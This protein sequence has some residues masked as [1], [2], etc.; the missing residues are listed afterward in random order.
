MATT[1][2]NLDQTNRNGRNPEDFSD[3]IDIQ[4]ETQA[5]ID[6]LKESTINYSLSTASAKSDLTIERT[7]LEYER[8]IHT[9]VWFLSVLD[10]LLEEIE[11]T[12]KW[13]S[14]KW[15]SKAWKKTMEEAKAKL[16]QYEKQLK[17]KKKTLLK[18]KRAE[19]YDND[20]SNLK[21]LW[22]QVNKVREDIWMWQRGEFSSTAS[23]LYNSPEIA[24]KSNKRQIDNIKFNQKLQKELKD[25]A[26]LRIFWWSEQKANSYYTRIAQ[27]EYDEAD[28]Q[29]YLVNEQI[30][31]PSFQRCEID[32]PTDPRYR[33]VWWNWWI[34]RTSRT[35][36]RSTDY[37]NMDWWDTLQKWWVAGVLDKLLS[38]CNNMTPWQR[39][40]W[41]SL[42]VLACFAGWIYWLYKFYTNKN[43]G[44]WSKAWITAWVIFGSQFLTWEWPISLFNKLIWWWLS[45]EELKNKFGNAVWWLWSSSS[46]FMET[47]T[48]VSWWA[49]E[50]VSETVV[51]AMYSMMIFNSSTKVSD[52][53]AMTQSFKDNNNRKAFYHQSCNT[54]EKEYWT[55]AAEC[56]RATFSDNFDEEKWK[57]RLASFG[58]T[59]NTSQWESLYWLANNATMNKII[60]EKFQTENWLIVTNKDALNAYIQDKKTNNQPID[61]DDLNNHINNDWT[62]RFK[63]DVKKTH[64]DRPED[65]TNREKLVN[66]VE[67][68]SLDAYQKEKL[69]QAIQDFYDERS[70]ENKPNLNDFELKIDWNILTL[71]SQNWNETKIDLSNNSLKINNVHFAIPSLSEALNTADLTNYI[72][73]LTNKKNPVDIPPFKYQIPQKAICFNDN[74]GKLNFFDTAI[75]NINRLRNR[76]TIDKAPNIYASYLSER[77]KEINKIN[78]TNYPLVKQLWISFYSNENE[79]KK[80]ENYLKWVKEKLKVFKC[81]PDWNP[82]TIE[83][84]TNRLKFKAINWDTEY[85]D[86]NIS[87]EFPTLNRKWNE[88]KFLNAINNPANKMR[89][90][91]FN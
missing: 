14:K 77:R 51:P 20:I 47:T 1:R 60:L 8:D 54:L 68:L 41:R 12:K 74:S 9:L 18:Q 29:L 59:E 17:G 88:K 10:K 58:V 3:I 49:W 57:N 19:I 87:K 45:I 15:L 24:K 72:L 66:K 6:N 65:I 56:F 33:I 7:W 21:N 71:K 63:V 27:W 91:V 39:E 46:W 70:I 22:N 2:W 81:H 5:W 34:E 69:K 86:E 38:N 11:D 40:T 62:D 35:V 43:M 53:N 78:L 67:S 32:I 31:N 84:L 30:L 82:F 75:L 44:F 42:W 26:I 23:Y 83:V 61:V 16:N 25:W 50:T 4:E 90:T 52:L 79:V 28:Y 13:I 37:S 55:E 48:W 89:W 36:R 85:F 76:S 80:L 64:T 73:K